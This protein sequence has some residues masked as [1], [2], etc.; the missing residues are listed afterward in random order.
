MNTR[1][2]RILL[3]VQSDMVRQAFS[4]LLE[5]AGFALMDA[6]ADRLQ[7][8][9]SKKRQAVPAAAVLDG[10]LGRAR[11]LQ[12]ASEI[13]RAYPGLNW[14]VLADSQDDPN[15]VDV[16]RAGARGYLLKSQPG[17]ELVAGVR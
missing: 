1:A 6:R 3:V 12:L 8:G 14:M 10:A 16:L 7:S 17:K 2:I 5:H 9:G 13:G 11:V 4:A 15:V